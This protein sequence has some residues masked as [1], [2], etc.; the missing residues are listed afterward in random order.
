MFRALS[1]HV[2]S[3]AGLPATL[4]AMPGAIGLHHQ[5][6]RSRDATGLRSGSLAG[7]TLPG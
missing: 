6:G 4:L 7:M 2:W 5:R 1:S 3:P